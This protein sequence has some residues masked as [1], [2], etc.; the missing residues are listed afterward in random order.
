[1][2]FPQNKKQLLPLTLG[3]VVVLASIVAH[4]Y[5]G[6][7]AGD[8][9]GLFAVLDHVFDLT[10]AFGLLTLV[11]GVGNTLANG[12]KLAFANVAEEIGASVF[13]G[14]GAVGLSVLLLGLIGLLRPWA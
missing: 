4:V 12:L 7:S 8:A 11:A 6:N 9:K 10:L 13:L 2:S 14:T 1:M 3:A 5:L